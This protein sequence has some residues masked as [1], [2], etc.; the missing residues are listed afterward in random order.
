[1]FQI[2][3]ITITPRCPKCGSGDV[4][5]GSMNAEGSVVKI[6]GVSCLSCGHE[7]RE[8]HTFSD[9]TTEEGRR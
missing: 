8:E 5:I 4:S 7:D 3:N 1:M 9:E 2:N 6:Q